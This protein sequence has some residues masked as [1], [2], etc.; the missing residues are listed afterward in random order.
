MRMLIHGD[1]RM[2]EPQWTEAKAQNAVYVYCAIKNHEIIIP[3]SCLFSWESDVISVTR[4]GF[5]TEFEI[6]ISKADFKADA[7]KER[8]R[9]LVAPEQ[10][11]FFGSY[12][13][14]RPNY[15]FYV[16]PSGN[17]SSGRSSRIRG[18]DLFE[19]RN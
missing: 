15:F 3:N 18:I 10:N 5:V 17:D 16:V 14:K 2:S 4:A 9:L 1:V 6:K 13:V 7:K 19:Q 8:A 11:G 12:S